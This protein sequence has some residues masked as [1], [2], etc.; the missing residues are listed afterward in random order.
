[1]AKL[2]NLDVSFISL[3]Q[4]PA[5]KKDIIAKA[6]DRYNFT[7][8]IKIT[9]SVKEGLVYGT[10]YEANNPD[11]H[12][13]WTDMETIKKA[14][15]DFLMKGK[16]FNIDT[17]HNEQQSGSALV[18]SYITDKGWDVVIKCD[19][20]SE[21]FE[22]VQKGEYAGLSM[23]GLAVK[24][25]EPAPTG[26]GQDDNLKKEVEEIKKGLTELTNILKGIPQ[27]RQLVFDQL[28]N[29]ITK[30]TDDEPF[31]ELKFLEV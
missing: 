27:S 8:S 6:S 30:N 11:A 29:V 28:G 25:D 26:A 2:T 9:K 16:N 12:G 7:K 19:P 18:E 1:M 14:A 24:K 21:V 5:N 4:N 3:V 15:H 10:V 20:K 13:D 17:D 23:M 22:K 31:S